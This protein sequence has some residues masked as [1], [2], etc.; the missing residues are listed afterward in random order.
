MF[1]SSN[2]W[3]AQTEASSSSNSNLLEEHAL[4]VVFIQE[5]DGENEEDKIHVSDF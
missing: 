5:T 3:K 2:T 1:N 4:T